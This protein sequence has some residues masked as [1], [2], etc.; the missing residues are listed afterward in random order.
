MKKQGGPAFPMAVSEPG[1][2]TH[3]ENGMT[4]RDWMAG[5]AVQGLVS[6]PHQS[7]CFQDMAIDAYELA[8]AMIEARAGMSPR[9][10]RDEADG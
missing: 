7:G 5:M 10:H 4:L 9:S 6:S 3:W 2:G 1:A 8:D